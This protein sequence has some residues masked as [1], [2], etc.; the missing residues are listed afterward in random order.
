MANELQSFMDFLTAWKNRRIKLSE[1]FHNFTFKEFNSFAAKYNAKKDEAKSIEAI[2]T[3]LIDLPDESDYN[4]ELKNVKQY[5][6]SEVAPEIALHS[7]MLDKAVALKQ[8]VDLEIDFKDVKQQNTAPITDIIMVSQHR[9]K[10]IEAIIFN[11]NITI[12]NVPSNE[13]KST[14]QMLT[15]L[16]KLVENPLTIFFLRDFDLSIISMA[17]Q[18][19]LQPDKNLNPIYDDDLL[20][21]MSFDPK[22]INTIFSIFYNA[23]VAFYLYCDKTSIDTRR[24]IEV[25]IGELLEAFTLEKECLTITYEDIVLDAEKIKSLPF[26]TFNN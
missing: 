5:Y 26:P 19:L 20:Y 16:D 14:K 17:A 9:D 23:C 11:I 10:W 15:F 24:Y 18:I 3:H 1:K 13:Y 7:E 25:A 6:M 2:I 4:P 21:N 8:G 22:E 12:V